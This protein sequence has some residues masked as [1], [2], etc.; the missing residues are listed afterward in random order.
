M[1]SMS[2]IRWKVPEAQGTASKMA[3]ADAPIPSAAQRRGFVFS[4]I[5]PQMASDWDQR[6]TLVARN[7]LLDRHSK[8][9]LRIALFHAGA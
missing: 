6:A 2:P 3:L 5:D 9:V 8:T 4:R 7:V 1:K